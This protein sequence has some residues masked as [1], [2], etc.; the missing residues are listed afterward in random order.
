MYQLVF[1]GECAPGTDEPQARANARALFKASVDQVERM[2]SGRP[3][4]IRNKLDREQAEKYR[5]VL[6]RHGMVSYV[7]PM[8]GT[9]PAGQKAAA[10]PSPAQPAV[11]APVPDKAPEPV[12]EESEGVRVEPGDRL[13][14]AGERVDEVLAGSRLALDPVGT[15]LAEPH[16]EEPPLFDHLDD[17]TMAPVGSD[18]GVRRDLPP[19][20]IPDTSHLSIAGEASGEEREPPR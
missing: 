20:I 12:A 15:R 2:F 13:P 10:A 6:A 3:V 16:D 9:A 17:W 8:A 1:R 18:I 7:E 5:A 19:P 4:V 11:A 14:V